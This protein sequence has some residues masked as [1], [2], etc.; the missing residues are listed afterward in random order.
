MRL[1][2]NQLVTAVLTALSVAFL[3]VAAAIPDPIPVKL[4]NYG[5]DRLV[6]LTTPSVRESYGITVKNEDKVSADAYYFVLSARAGDTLAYQEAWRDDPSKTKKNKKLD[7][8]RLKNQK[9]VRDTNY[10]DR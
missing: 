5:I 6:D 4:S 3:E 10:S 9:I 2:S 1:G 8:N 7:K